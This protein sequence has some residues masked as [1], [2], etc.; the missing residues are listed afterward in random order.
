M[1]LKER[2]VVTI[3]G[4]S[5]DIG[6]SFHKLENFRMP[7]SDLLVKLII[8]ISKFLKYILVELYFASS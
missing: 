7:L 3:M 2:V 6:A 8:V 4:F 5:Y 1:L